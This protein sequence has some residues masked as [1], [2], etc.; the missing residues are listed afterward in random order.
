MPVKQR[1]LGQGMTEY[2]IVVALV[3]VA[4]IAVYQLFGQVVRSQTAAMAR[5]L[6][7][8]DGSAQARAA[9]SAAG[10]AASQTRA[11]SLNSFTGNAQGA[12]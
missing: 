8:E 11:R 7:G 9:Q 3:A 2:I 5:E 6:A 4:A 10:R 12:K 1:Q